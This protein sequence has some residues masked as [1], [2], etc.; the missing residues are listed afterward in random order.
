M[1]LVGSTRC[2]PRCRR[3][4][5]FCAIA[6]FASTPDLNAG[7]PPIVSDLVV[8]EVSPAPTLGGEKYA[9][10]YNRGA[11]AID[12]TNWFWCDQPSGQYWRMLQIPQM[13]GAPQSP[14]IILQ[15]G[16]FLVIRVHP[17][18]DHPPPFPN[19]D[20]STRGN[21]S[22]TT[23][24]ITRWFVFP[25]FESFVYRPTANN[26]SI[27]D[28]SAGNPENPLFEFPAQMRDIAIWGTGGVFVGFKRGCTASNPLALLWP[29]E[30]FGDCQT[31]N[32]IPEFVAVPSDTLVAESNLSIN[33]NGG[34]ANDPS[35][36]FIAPSTEGERNVMPG[37]IDDDFDLD[38]DDA[39]E[40]ADCFNLAPADATCMRADLDG[41]DFVDCADWTMFQAHWA[42]YS[43]LPVPE[44]VPCDGCTMPGDFSGDQMV[45]ALD[46]QGY[47]DVLTGKDATPTGMCIADM[48]A[49]GEN[50][51]FDTPV[52]IL[53]A[54]GAIDTCL[55]GDANG[56]G[57][58]DALDIPRFIDALL[59]QTCSW[60][61]SA[62][63]CG[64]DANGDLFITID[65]V[66]PFISQTLGA[67]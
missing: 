62:V 55:H 25:G 18:T 58:L 37:D 39:A 60:E 46:I 66:D 64:L 27:W 29:P 50:D 45:N 19:G 65:D 13:T 9:E 5:W 17:F 21:N 28:L 22:G 8:N 47:V 36:Y 42:M 24:H 7:G 63:F 40:F 26:Y 35:D 57:K 41:S 44:F 43:L 48:N 52:F 4:W 1:Y 34:S 16:D 6:V 2:A 15:P 67:P 56:D 3:P 31:G 30:I 38:S 11:S 12:T 14:A 23:T 49:D 10:I 33:Y 53:T 20:Y 51:C 61:Q 59:T 54:T 32:P